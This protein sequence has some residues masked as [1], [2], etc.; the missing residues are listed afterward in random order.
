MHNSPIVN[1]HSTM[2][3]RRLSSKKCQIVDKIWQAVVF[4][5]FFSCLLCLIICDYIGLLQ[6]YTTQ[7]V[8]FLADV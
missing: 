6:C 3:M 8:K 1:I 5:M 2:A 4:A 7:N